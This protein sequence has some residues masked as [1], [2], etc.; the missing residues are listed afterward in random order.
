MRF[1]IPTTTGEVL[2]IDTLVGTF[3][4][5]LHALIT[6]EADLIVEIDD[7]QYELLRP[8]LLAA[9]IDFKIVTNI[10]EI[11]TPRSFLFE[12]DLSLIISFADLTIEKPE[13]AG[14]SGLIKTE[15]QENPNDD[16][17]RE[18]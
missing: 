14:L 12:D 13:N 11:P 5:K 17:G 3:K 10:P 15:K 16:D 6:T 1:L 7:E 2:H 9:D 8:V 18:S 4:T